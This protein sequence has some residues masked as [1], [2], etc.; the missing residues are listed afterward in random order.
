MSDPTENQPSQSQVAEEES[1][2]RA[3]LASFLQEEM[4]RAIQ[5]QNQWIDIIFERVSTLEIRENANVIEPP[6]AQSSSRPPHRDTRPSHP[7][8]DSS[9]LAPE[10][11]PHG[12]EFI[13]NRD[14]RWL[15]DYRCFA[16]NTELRPRGKMYVT[17][18]E[19][20]LHS[21]ARLEKF[22]VR[23]VDSANKVFRFLRA[24][25]DTINSAGVPQCFAPLLL[26]SYKERDAEREREL[27][28]GQG[29]LNSLASFEDF[30][31]NNSSLTWPE[32]L[33]S[34]LLSVLTI[35]GWGQK[36]LQEL[37]LLNLRR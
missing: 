22:S 37:W 30:S 26:S 8:E 31:L 17:D 18:A 19:R 15:A 11:Q 10:T 34:F 27:D 29:L 28:S 33:N 24:F 16:L 25:V 3:E 21:T 4:A 36:T 13:P 9:L 5:A 12:S 20:S 14:I 1:V 2:S 32:T 6:A 35:S 7:S 23:T